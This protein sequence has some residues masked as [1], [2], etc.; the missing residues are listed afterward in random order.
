VL[1]RDEDRKVDVVPTRRVIRAFL[2]FEAA[3]FIVAALVHAGILTTADPHAAAATGESVIA[4]ALLIGLALTGAGLLAVATIGIL[5]QGFALFGTLVG[6]LTIIAGVGPQSGPDIAYHV[7][8][9]G[10]LLVGVVV[11]SRRLP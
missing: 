3:T 4:I 8:I 7:A 6:I 5:A 2:A 9:S 10:V 11:A 1:L